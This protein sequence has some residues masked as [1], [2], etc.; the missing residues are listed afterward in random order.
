MRRAILQTVGLGVVLAAA[1][2]LSA[3]SLAWPMAWAVLAFYVA[4]SVAGF[5]LL[6][7]DLI[8]ERSSLPADAKRADLLVAGLAFL[9]LLGRASPAPPR[10]RLALGARARRA[11]LRVPDAPDRI[12]GARAAGGARRLH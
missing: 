2:F 12:R 10:G 8:A 1:P 3:G 5:L 9:F 4:F 7:P 6:P 11:R